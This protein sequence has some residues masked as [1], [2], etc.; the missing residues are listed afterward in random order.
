[1]RDHQRRSAAELAR[2]HQPAGR[3][4]C[5]CGRLLPCPVAVAAHGALVRTERRHPTAVGRAPVQRYWAPRWSLM[6]WVAEQIQPS[7]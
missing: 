4:L 2:L 5:R 3:E 7:S 6:T 1:M